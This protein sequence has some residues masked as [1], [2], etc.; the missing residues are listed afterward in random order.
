MS[1]A[2]KIRVLV[3]HKGSRDHFLAA[4]ALFKRG[5]LAGVVT[6]IRAPKSAGLAA[7]LS[8]S[9]FS[10]LKRWAA[11]KADDIPDSYLLSIGWSAIG[12]RSTAW[13]MAKLGWAYKGFEISDAMFARA[14]A[15]RDWPAHEIVFAYSYAALELIEA[16]KKKGILTVLNQID[17]GPGDEDLVQAEERRWPEY[18]LR[19]YRLPQGYVD[20]VKREWKLADIIVV[21]SEWSRDRIAAAGAEAGKIKVVPLAY[22]RDH[23]TT[24]PRDYG[25][26]SG[27]VAPSLTSNLP[28]PPSGPLK[29]LWV[30]NVNVRKGIQYVVEAARMLDHQPV[31]F[32]VAGEIGVP[33]KVIDSSPGNIQWLGPLP[34]PEAQR[35]YE[36]AGV[37]VLPTL[38][39]GFAMSQLEALANGVPVIVTANCGRVVE[40]GK[41]GF[42]VSHG[43]VDALASVI[44]RFI[45]D[46]SLSSRMSEECRKRATDFTLDAYG[47]RL[48]EIVDS[49][50]QIRKVEFSR[51]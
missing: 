43:D 15:R 22:E 28:P 19:P 25:T 3:V 34:R 23:G 48:M 2:S 7:I 37:F 30:G 4:R 41:S 10:V 27:P 16:E 24:G 45:Y 20:R 21:N 50:V 39:D 9:R 47:S 35:L 1:G 12:V 8:R 11:A 42:V 40:D 38:S 32:I 46:R 31:E 13:L 18:V 14:V 51:A 5:N 26:G 17:P 36:D 29:V 33:R 49:H 44:R 6:D